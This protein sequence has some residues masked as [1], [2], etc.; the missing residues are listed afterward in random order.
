MI[1]VGQDWRCKC[2]LRWTVRNIYRTDGEVLI[3]LEPYFLRMVSFKELG[4]KYELVAKGAS[5]G[6]GGG[7]DG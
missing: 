2:G 4:A 7:V 5:E 6:E 1:A 3:K